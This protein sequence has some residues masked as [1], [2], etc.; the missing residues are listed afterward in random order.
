MH[1]S[2]GKLIDVL[3][4]F[5]FIFSDNLLKLASDTSLIMHILDPGKVVANYLKLGRLLPLPGELALAPSSHMSDIPNLMSR[6]TLP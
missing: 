2:S 6:Y 4:E 3:E 1:S 5:L